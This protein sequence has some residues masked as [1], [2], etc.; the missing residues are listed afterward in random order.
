MADTDPPPSDYSDQIDP[1]KG[2]D[3][4][5][6]AERANKPLPSKRDALMLLQRLGF[7][8]HII[9]HQ[10]AVTRKALSL[11]H[12]IKRH[13]VNLDLIR[14]G[15]ML[16]DIG[17]VRTHD[18]THTS[19]GGDILRE[20]GYPEEL[21]RIAETHGLGGLTEDE[22]KKLGLPPKDYV[23]R[24]IEEKI[25]CLADKLLSGSDEVTIE[26]RF[27]RWLE[28]YG[29]TPFLLEQMRRVKQLEEE[30]LRLIYH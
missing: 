14:A 20:L 30:V 13:P 2:I 8:L 17:R 18:L 22:A 12:L 9:K 29:Q 21:A 1:I 3:G 25:V 15:A 7:P 6:V 26:Q 10:E 11:A 28:K 5:S 27:Q 16:H 19:A 24:T 4:I 23:P